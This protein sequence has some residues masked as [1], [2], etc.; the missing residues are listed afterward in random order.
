[1]LKLE[2]PSLQTRISYLNRLEI[3]DIIEVNH[4]PDKLSILLELLKKEKSN[5]DNFSE[6]S[7]WFHFYKISDFQI[8]IDGFMG[9]ITIHEAKFRTYEEEQKNFYTNFYYCFNLLSTSVSLFVK[10]QQLEVADF[11]DDFFFKK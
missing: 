6:Q 8:N 5:S 9:D 3:L 11:S 10:F 1:M 4:T 7:H 2:G